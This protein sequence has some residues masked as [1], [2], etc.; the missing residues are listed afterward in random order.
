DDSLQ[1]SGSGASGAAGDFGAAR[2]S[3]GFH[4]DSSH[5]RAA[6]IPANLRRPV[7]SG[8]CR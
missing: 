5:G 7:P 3:L 4:Q 1:L 8:E 2:L 6:P